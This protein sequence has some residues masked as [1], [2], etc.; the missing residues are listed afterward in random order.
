VH[1][2]ADVLPGEHRLVDVHD[3]LV[4]IAARAVTPVGQ[5]GV[6]HRHPRLDVRLPEL[7][8]P[9]FRGTV[10]GSKAAPSQAA[11]AGSRR[12]AGPPETGLSARK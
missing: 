7:L 11:S 10:L 5:G 1:R 4:A 6:H 8:W 12:N 3:H 9:R 2:D